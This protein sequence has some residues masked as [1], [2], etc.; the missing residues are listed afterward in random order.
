LLQRSNETLIESAERAVAQRYI[1]ALG[2]ALVDALSAMLNTLRGSQQLK[3]SSDPET[4]A[5]LG[6][7]LRLLPDADRLQLD[8][9]EGPGARLAALLASAPP[10]NPP[11]WEERLKAVGDE[12]LLR[13]VQRSIGLHSLTGGFAPWIRELQ[14]GAS[15][16]TDPT[17]AD[18]VSRDAAD[19]IEFAR[20]YGVPKNVTGVTDDERV[21]SYGRQFAVQLQQMHPTRFVQERIGSD[22]IPVAEDAKESIAKFLNANPAFRLKQTPML[23]YTASAD[24]N[25]GGLGEKA[26]AVVSTELLKI[27]RVATLVPLLDYVGPLISTSYDSARSIVHRRSRRSFME[28]MRDSIDDA[29]AGEIYDAAAGAAANADALVLRYGAPFRGPDLPVMPLTGRAG[30]ARMRRNA[31]GANLCLALAASAI[32]GN[33]LFAVGSRVR[34]HAGPPEPLLGLPR[35]P[36]VGGSRFCGFAKG[37]ARHCGVA[38]AQMRRRRPTTTIRVPDTAEPRSAVRR[39]ENA[40][41]AHRGPENRTASWRP[42][43]GRRCDAA[44]NRSRGV[45]CRGA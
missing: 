22:R 29:H 2:K 31:A 45:V 28:E 4:T 5:S 13:S 25:D 27:E 7:T 39:L 32:W 16:D 20:K 40:T 42:G 11:S 19:W 17:L 37:T 43:T 3:P 10:A 18:L 15:G 36:E 12:D 24:F 41:G 9:P 1:P 21:T 8:S 23:A 14:Q 30:Q 34:R 33:G 44:R 38:G 6:D 26:L 35:R